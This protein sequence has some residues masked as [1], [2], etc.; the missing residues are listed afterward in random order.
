MRWAL[1]AV[2]DRRVKH[3]NGTVSVMRYIRWYL[4]GGQAKTK[5]L[6]L[7]VKVSKTRAN[8]L[9]DKYKARD[10]KRKKSAPYHDPLFSDYIDTYI[11][12]VRYIQKKR[13]WKRDVSSIRNLDK[14]F[15]KHVLSEITTKQIND[16]REKRLAAGKSPRTVNLE[17]SCLSRLF[18]LAKDQE[19]FIDENPVS[20]I[21]PFEIHYG[22]DRILS[23]EEEQKLI[24]ASP[25]HLKNIITC[26]LNT[27]MRRGE[28]I[29]L[30]WSNVKLDQGYLLLEATNTKSKRERRVP[31]NFIMKELLEELELSRGASVFLN[32]QGKPYHDGIG[33][34]RSFYTARKKAGI[35]DFRFH[36]LR[37]T[38]ATRMV[39][40]GVSLFT[41]GQILGHT[42]P[43]TTMRYAHPD[44]SLKEG[45]EALGRY[46]RIIHSNTRDNQE[47]KDTPN[48]P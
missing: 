34:R 1:M 48:A 44:K 13:S 30:K 42:D 2:F 36:D 28:I 39:E 32:S 45:I 26:A 23:P 9:L 15:S 21:K 4:P 18:R 19:L 10:K 29:G 37:H 31:I 3:K 11:N 22:A 40:A 43:K 8:A 35:E 41:V 20:N 38:A 33:I 27:G 24:A 17:M 7:A 5:S 47:D 12:H 6:G 25:A 14:E 46:N 16:Y